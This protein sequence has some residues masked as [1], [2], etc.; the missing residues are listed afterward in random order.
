MAAAAEDPD[1]L[2]DAVLE[3]KFKPA[4]RKRIVRKLGKEEVI[5]AL[6]EE[7]VLDHFTT[8]QLEAYLRRKKQAE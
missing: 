2:L 6:G 8:E 5:E 3:R 1:A 7:S 4:Q